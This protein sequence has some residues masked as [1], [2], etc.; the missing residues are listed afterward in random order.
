[1]ANPSYLALIGL[2]IFYAVLLTILCTSKSGGVKLFSS[3]HGRSHRLVGLGHLLSLVYGLTFVVFERSESES[4]SK[5]CFLFDITLG[6]L[7]ITATLSAAR[8]FPHRRVINRPGESGTLSKNAIVTQDEMV[9]HSFYQGMNLWQALYLHSITWAESHLNLSGRNTHLR[10]I[11]LGMVTLP[12]LWRKKFP[13][14]SFS[15]NWTRSGEKQYND[16]GMFV[17]TE[18]KPQKDN[19]NSLNQM[20]QVKK[21]QYIL[22]KHVILHGLNISMAFP[23]KQQLEGL[24]LPLTFEWRIFWLCLNSSYVM[25]FFMQSLVKRGVL[26]QSFMLILQWIL[27]GSSSLSVVGAVLRIVR[28]DAILLSLALNFLHRGHDISNTFIAG[29]SCTII[30]SWNIT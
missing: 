26:S 4:W 27:M 8:D 10:F 23:K 25:E 15:S 22:Y 19:L 16:K 14:N 13:V 7:G 29:I 1:M 17:H 3:T 11:A 5:R 28:Y 18:K 24:P 21:W 2:R 9:E 30:N 20:Y 6:F 12:W